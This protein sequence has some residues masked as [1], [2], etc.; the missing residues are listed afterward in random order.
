MIR[1][2]LTDDQYYL[3]LHALGI[4]CGR[5]RFDSVPLA[6]SI[7][8]LSRHIVEERLGGSSRADT[9][10]GDAERAQQP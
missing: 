2:E 4:A 8:Q 6:N 5:A 1:I 3:L 10:T 9:H 7:F